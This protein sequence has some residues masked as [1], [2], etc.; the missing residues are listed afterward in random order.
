MLIET[1]MAFGHLVWKFP[2]DILFEIAVHLK[3]GP[4]PL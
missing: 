2:A 4:V 3:Q 1:S